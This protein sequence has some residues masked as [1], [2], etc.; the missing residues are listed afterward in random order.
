M[1]LKP[2]H[3]INACY[4]HFSKQYAGSLQ[5]LKCLFETN[6]VEYSGK[7][8]PSFLRFVIRPWENL[9]DIL[10][11]LIQGMNFTNANL[12]KLD[13]RYINFK[14][15]VLKNANLSG[16]NLSYCNFER[17]DLCHAVLDVSSRI[18]RRGFSFLF[19]AEIYKI[20]AYWLY[21][22]KFVEFFNVYF[23]L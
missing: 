7:N 22:I 14:Y 17:A 10:S 18:S 19:F 6:H 16:A 3:E 2:A 8:F 13:L 15:A 9:K 12:S 1:Y 21:A 20:I 23:Y 11:H 5:F 4:W